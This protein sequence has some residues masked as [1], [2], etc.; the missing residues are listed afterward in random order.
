MTD[1]PKAIH[2]GRNVKRFREA[3][4]IKQEV[5]ADML[6]EGWSQKKV[7]QIENSE[8]LDAALID[9][10][11]KALQVSPE[12]IKNLSEENVINIIQHNYDGSSNNNNG[13]NYNNCSIQNPIDKIIELQEEKTKLY[14]ALLKEKDEKIALLQKLLDR[15]K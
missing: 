12:A 5:F 9:E 14:E 13:P 3:K 8:E 6:G 10:L 1:L 11:A 7:S 15:S 2:H 4:K